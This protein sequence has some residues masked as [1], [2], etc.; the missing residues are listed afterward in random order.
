[1]EAAAEDVIVVASDG[2]WNV[3]GQRRPPGDTSQDE[4][5]CV[6]LSAGA[7]ARERWGDERPLACRGWA[8]E[9]GAAW[10]FNTC[11]RHCSLADDLALVFVAGRIDSRARSCPCNTLI[12]PGGRKLGDGGVL[13]RIFTQLEEGALLK[14]G[15]LLCTGGGR[16]AA[17]GRGSPVHRRRKGRC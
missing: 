12:V 16:G 17:E 2:L 13:A 4:K 14:E 9:D 8:G 5:G 10:G 6:P 15:A 1:V 11:A 3:L 7:G